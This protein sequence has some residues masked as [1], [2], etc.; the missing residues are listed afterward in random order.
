MAPFMVRGRSVRLLNQTS[1]EIEVNDNAGG[2]IT[3][4]PGRIVSFPGEF[5]DAD[6]RRR[7]ASGEVRI[8]DDDPADIGE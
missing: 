2:T 4:P 7:L 5:A 1:R 8:I 3:L 6:L